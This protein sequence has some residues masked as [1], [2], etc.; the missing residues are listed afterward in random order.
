M[1]ATFQARSGFAQPARAAPGRRHMSLT[2]VNKTLT[3]D[4][5]RNWREVRL[6]AVSARGRSRIAALP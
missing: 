2:V 6:R 5:P 4:V 1:L 3:P